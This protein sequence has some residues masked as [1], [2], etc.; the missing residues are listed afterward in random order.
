MTRD[1]AFTQLIHTRG[2]HKLLN[3]TAKYMTWLRD[4]NAKREGISDEAKRNMLQKAGAKIT[5]EEAWELPAIIKSK[6]VEK[7]SV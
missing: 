4:K 2:S 5:Q 6:S 3:R 1:E 7:Q